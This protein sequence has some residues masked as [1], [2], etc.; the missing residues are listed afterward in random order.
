VD[1]AVTGAGS[2]TIDVAVCELPAELSPGSSEWTSFRD[3]V[4]REAPDL[5]LLN[6]MPF[7]P[8]ISSR[9]EFD[10]T[11]WQDSLRCHAEGL[12]RI[13][14]LGAGAVAGSRPHSLSG[15]RV[16]QAFV[17]ARGM[18]L[19]V[20]H[21]KQYFPNEEGYYEARWF[22][23][24]PRHFAPTTAV[25]LSVAFLICTE[26]M[27]NEH[28]RQCGRA[29]ADILLVPRAVGGESIRR[30]LVAARMAAIV[31]GAYV[32]SSNRAGGDSRGQVFGGNG[33]IIDPF[34]DVVALTSASA[35]LAVHRIDL[36]AVRKAKAEYPCY[37]KETPAQD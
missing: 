2:G 23:A 34:G 27:F 21:T 3:A 32:L 19:R 10:E 15:R 9:A 26:L 16:N 37:V 31:S 25:G 6:E 18:E 13:D 14:E 20:G 4:A 12:A 5:L 36:S 35:P 30:W 7:G 1:S 29:G 33:W 8:W 11:T 28:A 22:E 17:W 24:G